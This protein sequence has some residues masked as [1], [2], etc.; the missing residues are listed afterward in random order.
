MK[1]SDWK[2]VVLFSFRRLQ[3][4]NNDPVL[5]CKTPDSLCKSTSDM[6]FFRFY[7]FF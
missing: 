3:S 2:T 7:L 6:L 5:N 4:E 1:L